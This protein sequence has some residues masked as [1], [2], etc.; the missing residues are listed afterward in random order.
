[1]YVRIWLLFPWKLYV[2]L[3]SSPRDAERH[4]LMAV[5]GRGE[6][7]DLG[8]AVHRAMV[9]RQ[10]LPW[11]TSKRASKGVKRRSILS[12]R[13]AGIAELYVLAS[14]NVGAGVGTIVDRIAVS[15]SS[16]RA[17]KPTIPHFRQTRS[18]TGGGRHF[19]RSHGHR[20]YRYQKDQTKRSHG[21][22]FCQFLD[23]QG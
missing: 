2:P 16:I 11:K 19:V 21:F 22:S 1:V 9:A 4:P 5:V 3:L 20:Q 18:S 8:V 14:A 12:S 17:L 23:Q 10:A 6:V 15:S 13:S 7:C